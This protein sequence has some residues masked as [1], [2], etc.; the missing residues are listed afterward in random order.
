LGIY[1]YAY[2]KTLNKYINNSSSVKEFKYQSIDSTFI[3]DINGSKYAT[4][5]KVYRYGTD[6]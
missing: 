3:E 5:N 2:K 6:L 4:Y 1:E